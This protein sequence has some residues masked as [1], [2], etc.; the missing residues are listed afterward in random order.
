MGVN[1]RAQHGSRTHHPPRR[2]APT[3]IPIAA[4]TIKVLTSTITSVPPVSS[5]SVPNTQLL[6]MGFHEST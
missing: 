1:S 4:A 2:A 6:K 5:A 3:N